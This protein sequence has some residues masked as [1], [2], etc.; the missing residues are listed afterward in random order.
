MSEMHLQ[1]GLD[2]MRESINSSKKPKSLYH[3]DVE[4]RNELGEVLFKKSNTIV[5]GGRRFT[6][7][8]LFNVTATNSKLTLNSI[9]G[10]SGNS[11]ITDAFSKSCVCL[12][13][14]GM[15]GS[16]LTFGSV[17]NPSSKESNLYNLVPLQYVDSDTDIKS[18][19]KYFMCKQHENGKYAFYLK[20]FESAA[21]HLI[22]NGQEYTPSNA[23]NSE[24]DHGD[25][26]ITYAG[27]DDVD[28]YIELNLKIDTSDV[29]AY[30]NSLG[31]TQTP[32][33][34]ELGLFFGCHS[35]DTTWTEYSNVELFSKLTFNNEALDSET[36]ELN[37]IYRIYI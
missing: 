10:I 12:F 37:I 5:L 6:L 29:R 19:N 34:N 32:R 36:K 27:V 18:T 23:D 35:S 4:C 13:G 9:L 28:A 17:A 2:T 20:R 25:S 3:T 30:F 8:K 33:I 15:G 1:D 16:G 26:A 7:E 24:P 22:V 14:V 21:I 11:D 31:E